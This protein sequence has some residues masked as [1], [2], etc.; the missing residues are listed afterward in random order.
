MRPPLYFPMHSGGQ[1]PAIGLGT[2]QPDPS[3]YPTKSVKQSVLWALEAGYRHFD[4]SLRYGDGQGEKEVGEAIRESGIPREEIFVVTK[5]EN[6][7][8]APEDVEVNLDISLDNLGLDYESIFIVDLFI[9]HFPYAYK[10]TAN[11]GT[12]RDANGRP[13]IDIDLSRSFD[14]TWRAMEKLVG[15]N[16]AKYIGLS[17][18]SS[19][20]IKRL[21]QTAKIR[22]AVNQIECHPHWP[23]K[24][25]VK[26]CQDNGIHVTA[27][28]PLGCVPIPSLI[29]RT[30]PGPLEDDTIALVAR[31]YSKTP[32][33]VI[34]CYL[35]CRG[36]SVIPKS[37]DEAR[38][39]QNYD[40]IFEMEHSD[41]TLIDNITGKYGERGVRNF[42]SLDY[43]GFDNYNEEVEEP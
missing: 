8:H 32:A 41:F 6:V 38:I 29:G 43:L 36:I 31:K 37:N 34:L 33:Q 26:L 24:G 9:M 18:F 5:L 27:F 22:P 14:V 39:V 30:G 15:A 40:C 23:Q 4:T 7:Y 20:K 16:K 12:E 1:I 10:K 42:N 35:L 21:L 17:N 25:L 13:V 19:P 3:K 2:F 28:G 11:Y